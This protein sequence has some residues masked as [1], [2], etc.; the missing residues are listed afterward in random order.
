MLVPMI[1]LSLRGAVFCLGGAIVLLT[2]N[3]ALRTFVLPR[4]ARDWLTALVFISLRY[5]FNL[6]VSRVKRYVRRDAIMAV[7]APLALMLLLPVWYTLV[8]FGYTLMFWATG[9]SGLYQAFLTSGSSLLTLGFARSD[10]LLHLILIYSEATIGLLLVALLIAYLPTMYSAFSQR[11][12]AVTRLEVRAGSPPSAIEF[13]LR[14]HRLERLDVLTDVWRSWEEWF[15]ALDESHTS[16]APLVFFRSPTPGQS[17]VTAAGA[18]LDAASLA[19][20]TLDIPRDAQADI[21]IRS[22]YLALRRIADFFQI[23]H[24]PNPHFPDDPISI[25]REE[26]DAVYDLFQEE[27]LPLKP[28]EQAWLDF[29]GWRVN[30]DTVLLA[31]C[32]LTMAPYAPWSSDRVEKRAYNPPFRL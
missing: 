22:G 26:F 17:W 28:R 7:Y 30:Y 1:E 16:L 27:G 32:H 13:M 24:N 3:S 2:L 15:S 6:V 5:L 19:T 8:T 12:E 18:V 11:E 29:A 20:S 14:H 10:G 23:S 4:S 9:V 21:C 31:L 25:R